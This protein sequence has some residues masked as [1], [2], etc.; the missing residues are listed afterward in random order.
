[1][2]ELTRTSLLEESSPDRF[3]CHDLLHAYAAELAESVDAPTVRRQALHRMLD[4]YLH[5][6]HSAAVLLNPDRE[7]LTLDA[8]QPGVTAEKLADDREALAWL[9][10][11]HEVLVAAIGRAAAAGFDRHV[12]QLA[13]T[14]T[15]IFDRQGRWHAWAETQ[16]A[17]LQAAQRLGDRA[18]QAHS[19]RNLAGG[20][21]RLGRYDE[22]RG[23][24]Q[25]ALRLYDQ[26]GDPAGKA[27][28]CLNLGWLCSEEGDHGQAI[29]HA[30]LA[31]KLALIA[32]SKAREAA[33]SNAVG[34]CHA[35]LGNPGEAL[36]YCRR[37]VAM[38][39]ELGDR[40]GQATSLDS[41]GYVYSRLGLQSRAIYQY[42]DALDLYRDM[43]NQGN[44]A[45]VLVHLG[46]AHQ[47]AGD[48]GAAWQAWQEA[49]DVL[50]G[51]HH[52]DAGRIHARLRDF[53]PTL[54]RAGGES[55]VLRG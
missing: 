41:L 30:Q 10:A 8:P 12:W 5:T 38:Y 40:L 54:A 55:L 24:L 45:N 44:V 13:W 16:T 28:A 51:L 42:R 6:A 27:R 33:A 9:T 43:R 22:A 4:H 3:A 35:L 20:Y 32:G 19:H 36:P 39:R 15:N 1:L 37:A 18:G 34:W 26:I 2:G 49:A 14:L 47:A 17:A 31:L 53:A 29:R 46:D 48:I 50:D 21:V 23:H 52:P 11:E 7:P 25:H